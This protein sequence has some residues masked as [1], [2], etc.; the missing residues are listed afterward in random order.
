MNLVSN[1]TKFTQK[2]Y[3]K[4]SLDWKPLIKDNST[5]INSI[6]FTSYKDKLEKELDQETNIYP[7]GGFIMLRMMR[8]DPFLF[9]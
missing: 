5:S 4:V 9:Q 8:K 1:A 3:I 7:P 2:G 6:F